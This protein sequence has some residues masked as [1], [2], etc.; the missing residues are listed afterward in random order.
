MYGQA[1]MATGGDVSAFAKAVRG[2]AT[3]GA[4]SGPGTGTSDSVPAVGP[5]GVPFRL[6]NGEHVWTAAEVEAVGGQSATY[7]LRSLAKTGALRPMVGYRDGG[8]VASWRRPEFQ[9]V[10]RRAYQT[11]RPAGGLPQINVTLHGVPMDVANETAKAVGHAVRALVRD[12]GY[13][14][15]LP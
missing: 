7:A 5:F 11:Q 12:T 15:G 9:P 1:A 8:E 10:A 4:V 14:G 3:G 6:S 2:Y 13:A